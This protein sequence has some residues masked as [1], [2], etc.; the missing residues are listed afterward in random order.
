[1][2]EFEN[3]SHLLI[4]RSLS[5]LVD[6]IVWVLNPT[7]EQ[8]K[9]YKNARI[10]SAENIEK[11]S[12][13]QKITLTIV[14]NIEMNLIL[15]IMSFCKIQMIWYFETEFV[16]IKLK[17]DPVPFRQTYGSLGLEK[18]KDRK[19]IVGYLEPD[20]LFE[21]IHSD[22]AGLSLIVPKKESLV[23]R[24]RGLNKQIEKTC[25]LLP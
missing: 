5:N 4:A 21:P 9:A 19:K 17:K 20:D 14:Q 10:A 11:V 1:M 12:K 23:V 2:K 7:L 8:K 25:W 24:Y 6:A 18:I 3:K 15:R 13:I 22:W 16:K